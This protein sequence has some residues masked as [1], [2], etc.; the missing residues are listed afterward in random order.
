MIDQFDLTSCIGDLFGEM[1]AGDTGSSCMSVGIG[2]MPMRTGFLH[3]RECPA[4]RCGASPAGFRSRAGIG[5][6]LA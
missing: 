3:A 4:M 5:A 2:R 1:S 6:R